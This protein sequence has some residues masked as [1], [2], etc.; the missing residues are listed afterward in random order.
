VSTNDTT[1]VP[2]AQRNVGEKT[3]TIVL[4]MVHPDTD[5]VARLSAAARGEKSNVDVMLVNP[6]TPDG[7]IWIR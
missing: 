7:A 1:P 3:R 6:P 4:P 5:E 2:K